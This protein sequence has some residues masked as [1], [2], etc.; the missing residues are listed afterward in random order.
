MKDAVILI[1]SYEP[2][3]LL[4]NVVNELRENDFPILL[5]NDGSGPEFDRVFSIVKDKV[6]YLAFDHNRG[7]GAA[8]KYGYSKLLELYPDAKYVITADGDGQHSLKDIVRVYNKMKETDQLVF[9]VRSFGRDV[10]FRSRFGN[11]FSK[12]TRSLLTKTYIQDDQCG[13]RGFPVRYIPDLLKITG[14]R[15]E[16]E[17]NE[18]VVFQMMQSPLYTLPIETIYL[19]NNSRS[20]FAPF[21]DTFRI[22]TIIFLHAIPAIICNLLLVALMIVAFHFHMDE[23]LSY[24]GVVFG[25]YT[26]LFLI[27]F[28]IINIVYPTRN[29]FRRLLKELLFTALKMSSC[30]LTLFLTVNLLHWN[31]Y[32]MIP[33]SVFACTSLNVAFAWL[34]RKMFPSF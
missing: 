25:S 13:L 4:I 34:F 10:P 18:M 24:F 33:I 6:K 26:A 27:Y 32:A 12:T 14:N 1:P 21:K 20:H 2:D 19:D 16:Y 17:M 28:L 8:M 7:K 29:F 11:D 3:D 23:T 22:Q 30:L 5:V 31:F 15:Y 9:G